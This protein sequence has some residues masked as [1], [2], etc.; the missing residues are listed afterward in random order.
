M[1]KLDTVIRNWILMS[2]RLESMQMQ[3][4]RVHTKTRK[5]AKLSAALRNYCCDAFYRSRQRSRG[6]GEGG[7]C[8]D[9]WGRTPN[10]STRLSAAATTSAPRSP[11]WRAAAPKRAAARPPATMI[12]PA[13]DW[14]K[15]RRRHPRCT[16]HPHANHWAEKR[17]CTFETDTHSPHLHIH[18]RKTC[19]L[20]ESDEEA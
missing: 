17:K 11:C 20:K 6:S 9:T 1:L 13:Y 7:T 18:C 2:G 3:A 5:R 4:L 8:R 16:K 15:L 19:C 12:C 14:P 10:T